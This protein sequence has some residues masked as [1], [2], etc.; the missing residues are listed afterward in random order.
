MKR[1][2]LPHYDKQRVAQQ[3][4]RAAAHYTEHDRLQRD[5]AGVLYEHLL[6]QLGTLLDI[7][8]G[9]GHHFPQ[10]QHLA[11][12]YI[13]VDLAPQMLAKAQQSFPMGT[14]QW[15]DME[16]L[17][18]ADAS[19]QLL[20][21]NLAMQWANDPPAL[22]AEWWRVLAPGGRWVSS[23]VLAGSL[24][25]LSDCFAAVDA[26]PHMNQ[27]PSLLAYQQW[28]RQVAP[29]LQWQQQE[30][31]QTFSSLEQMLRELKGVGANYTVRPAQGCYTKQRLRKLSEAM[32]HYRNSQ[33][34]L[35]LK[36]QIGIA[37]GVKPN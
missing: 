19:L 5:V 4:G 18:F 21:S 25:P 24:Q 13:G 30:F 7:G 36:W 8:C 6:P 10:L 11:D 31:I 14:F 29:Q 15:A 9:P 20:Y 32:E 17:P 28:S 37:Y 26:V 1:E 27:W 16:A 3:F 33:G 35:E 23:T 34:L 2:N 12:R 22:L